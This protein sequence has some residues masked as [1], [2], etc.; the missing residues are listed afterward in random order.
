MRKYLALVAL[1]LGAIAPKAEATPVAVGPT[2]NIYLAGGNVDGNGGIAP[3][4]FSGFAAIP[5]LALTLSVSGTMSP[6]VPISCTSFGPDG[7]LSAA[8]VNAPTSGKLSGVTYAGAFSLPLFGVFLGNSLPAA[9]PSVLDFTS[10]GTSF[11]S[12]SPVLGQVFFIGDGLTGTGAGATQKFF[13]PTGATH[14]YLG[15]A[16]SI[17]TDNGGSFTADVQTVAPSATVPEPSTLV[18]TAFGAAMAI[19]R[20]RSAR[21][22]TAS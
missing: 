15:L 12:L 7:D 1:V 11:P 10:L 4:D 14:L 16:D 5:G 21:K 2:A 22:P 9:A 19:R 3:A 17:Y 18:L 20:R 13:V 8:T 6:C